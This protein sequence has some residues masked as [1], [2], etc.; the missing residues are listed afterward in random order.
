MA[1]NNEVAPP[2]ASKVVKKSVEDLNIEIYERVFWKCM[3]AAAR[4]M[5][6]CDGKE[7]T[8]EVTAGVMS[9]QVT[10]ASEMFNRYFEDQAQVTGAERNTK[11]TVKAVSDILESRR[12]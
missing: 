4:V 2:A 10:I 11:A 3:G 1:E 8:A 5:I 7:V 6:A 12:V 9:S